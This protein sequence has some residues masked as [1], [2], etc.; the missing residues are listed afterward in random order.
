VFRGWRI[1]SPN[2]VYSL[3]QV[4]PI[5]ESTPLKRSRSSLTPLYISFPIRVDLTANLSPLPFCIQMKLIGLYAH[6]DGIFRRNPQSHTQVNQ[7]AIIHTRHTGNPFR[8]EEGEEKKLFPEVGG[9]LG[10]VYMTPYH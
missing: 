8:N 6:A 1:H 5:Y 10:V 3:S 4:P 7:R 9:K 2:V